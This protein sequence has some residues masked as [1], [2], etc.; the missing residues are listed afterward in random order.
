MLK[1]A[2]KELKLPIEN[3]S[4]LEF[5]NR[6]ENEKLSSWKE[7]K[8]HGQ[9]AKDTDDI[10][11]NESFSWLCKGEFK[12]ET[13]SLILAAQEQALN[14]NSVKARIYHLQENDQM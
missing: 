12:R 4:K 9:S 8:L 11:T 5:K 1:I 14:T 13:E 6:K 10:K 2:R 3:E 7:K